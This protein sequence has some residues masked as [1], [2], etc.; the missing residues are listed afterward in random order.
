MIQKTK[1][2]ESTRYYSN[3]QEEYVAKL[4]GGYQTPNSGATN[5]T[6]GD[7]K[8][9][10]ASM[11]IECKT[12]TTEKD[13]I[14][15]KKDWLDKNNYETKLMRLSNSMLVFNFGPNTKNYFIIDEKLAKYLVEKLI[16]ENN[17]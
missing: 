9:P 2:K 10:N 8:I 12:M 13:S 14:S 11:L 1:N 7:I 3:L 4:L 15:I 5:F 16:E 17:I 6:K